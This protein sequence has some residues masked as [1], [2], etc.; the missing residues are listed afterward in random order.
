M[1]ATMPATSSTTAHDTPDF[2]LSTFEDRPFFEKALRHGVQTG[3]I[4][5]TKISAINT[6]APKGIVQIAAAFGSAYLRNELE[7]ARARMVH[8][9]S[10]FLYETSHGDLDLAAR[11]IRDNTILTLSRGGSGLIKELAALPEFPI[12]TQI[13]PVRIEEFLDFWSRKKSIEDYRNARQH[14]LQYQ[15]E[16]KLA[17]KL[18]RALGLTEADYLDQHSE[19]D[20]LIRS[21][22]LVKTANPRKKELTCFDPI[23][24]AEALTRLRSKPPAK[25]PTPDGEFTTDELAMLSKLQ[26]DILTHDVPLI[27]NTA[28]PLDVLIGQL[29]S[30][31]FIRDQDLEDTASYDALVSKEWSKFTKGKA[32]IDAILTLLLCVATQ[33][34]PKVSL[35]ES[36]AKTLIRKIRQ[37]GFDTELAS[38]FVRQHAPHEKQDSLLE[39]WTDF[40][41][42]AVIYLQDDWDQDLQLAMKFLREN[43]YIE[44]TGKAKSK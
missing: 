17:K 13:N 12:L 29:K 34:P 11:A 40:A 39:D 44:K 22:L 10:L 36:A 42:Q 25:L 1:P 19:A 8:L 16:I 26:H 38:N 20:A 24:F 15:T 18:G 9:I 27:A 32:D 31:Y 41:E 14:R 30:R 7:T 23:G 28:M 5:T 3:L 2:Q 4:D 21:A 37:D 43:C 35:T 6:D 33:L